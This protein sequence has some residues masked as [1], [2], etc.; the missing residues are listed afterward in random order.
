M[1]KHLKAFAVLSFVLLCIE[2][3]NNKTGEYFCR[4]IER[5]AQVDTIRGAEYN[6]TVTM[7][8]AVAGQCDN[9]PLITADGSK[10]NPKKA[11]EHKWIAVSQDMLKKNGGKL[12]YGDFVE[13]KGTGDKDGI[14]EVHDCMNRRFKNRIDILETKGT[15]LYQY[16]NITLT[17]VSWNSKTPKENLLVSL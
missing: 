13:I 12:N 1:K 6:V 15:E 14:Y 4:V 16:K 11:T 2:L 5:S 8:Y 9:S 3:A 7:Y 17:Q 10:I